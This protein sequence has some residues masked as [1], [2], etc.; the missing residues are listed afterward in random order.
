MNHN[1]L[2]EL[3]NI[4]EERSKKLGN[5][6]RSVLLKNLPDF[7]NNAIHSQHLN[8]ILNSLKDEDKKILDIGCGYGRIS[9]E[10][11]ERKD[12][13]SIEGVEISKGFSDHFNKHIGKCYN[14]SLQDFS[15][16]KK[17]DVVIIVTV[18]MYINSN[19]ELEL[20][21]KKL[22]SSLNKNGRIICIE[23]AKNSITSFRQKINSRRFEPT[24]KN[25]QYYEKNE[26]LK[27][28]QNL[29]NSVINEEKEI[30][31]FPY[32]HLP[33]IHRAI[34]LTKK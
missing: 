16:H 29:S 33:V 25:V 26:L 24:G 6:K 22:W 7:I 15:P 4:W 18:L 5:S 32:I 28:F 14:T 13:L 11:L 21:L 23:P 3:K 2:N 1:N 31:L 9:Q 10:L 8:F 20:I 17:Y 27:V 12:N 19:K 34:S 30:G